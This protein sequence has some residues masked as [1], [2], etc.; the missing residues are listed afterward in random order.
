MRKG[1]LGSIA[2]LTAGAGAAWGQPQVDPVVTPGAPSAL[3]GLAAP[4]SAPPPPDRVP[5]FGGFSGSA[6]PGNQGYAPPP[7]ILPPGNFGPPSDPLGLGPVGGFG[8]PPG[9]MYPMP[10]PYAQ[11]SY[12]PNPPAPD[13][14]SGG[15]GSAP[16]WWFEGD[17]LLWFNRG[18]HVNAPLVTTSAQSDGG[19]PGAAST[20]VLSGNH[21]LGYNGISGMRFTAGFFGD[22][23]RRF[24]FQMTGFI[25]ETRANVQQFG[26]LDNNAG[27][28][29]LARPFVDTNG[30]QSS[31]VLS[32][33]SMG[34]GMVKV[35]TTSQTWGVEPEGVWNIF[36]A[37]PGKKTLFSIDL[38]AGYRFIQVK[39]GLSVSSATELSSGN[40]IP[41]FT[42]GPFGIITQ[43][44]TTLGS[45][46][47]NVGGVTVGGPAIIQVVDS[48]NTT[49]QFNGFVTGLKADARY[50]IFTASG[51]A[52]IAIGDMHERVQVFGGTSITSQP[53]PAAAAVSTNPIAFSGLN[54]GAYGGVLA[55]ASNIGTYSYD[56]FT[57][58]PEVGLNLGIAVTRGLTCY[59][60]GN[61]MYFPD[62][63]RPGGVITT[64]SS[65][66]ALPFSSNY[67]ASGAA[68]APDIK[69]NQEHYWLGGVN[70]GL[71]YRY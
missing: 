22:D 63:I 53:N 33:P 36:R 35:A 29:V 28:P 3:P 23:D 42:T 65:S 55:N 9:P 50:G 6:I 1:L 45:S 60:G 52:K 56:R 39:E 57:Y 30:Q 14:S 7:A 27:I 26:S 4:G 38:I 20:L 15:F 18:Q 13:L 58:I 19:L 21:T 44:G 11:Q 34:A 70:I 5:A 61:F 17:Y 43:T 41:T 62:V 66:A 54:G 68:R 64:A 37:E 2:A 46:T 69:F 32:G 25:L 59:I 67:G 31:V 71:T 10:G 24:G 48:F 47:A 40:Q 16:R 8:P 51:F 49:N 12:Q